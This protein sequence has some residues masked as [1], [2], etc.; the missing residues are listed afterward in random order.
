M[1]RRAGRK[2]KQG[3]RTPNG[4]LARPAV[5]YGALAALQPHR[6]DLPEEARLSQDATTEL[7]K[8]FLRGLITEAEHLAGQ[9]Y[10]RRRGQYMATVCGPRTIAGTS[11]WSGCNP[12]ECLA[13]AIDGAHH[14]CECQRRRQD[15]QE[16]QQVI[17]RCGRKV[18][19]ALGWV[20]AYD[21]VPMA[22]EVYLLSIGLRAL[23]R[24]MRL[25]NGHK[26]LTSRNRN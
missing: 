19:A 25:T 14:S 9:E 3:L 20:I 26:A 11:R 8:A 23:A 22:D 7:G 21:R 2:R 4:E 18:E 17:S 16:M 10:A 15:Y 1:A 6:R 5:N 13:L 24:H 12:D